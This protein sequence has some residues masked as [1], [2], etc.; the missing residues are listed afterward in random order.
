MNLFDMRVLRSTAGLFAAIVT[1]VISTSLTIPLKY[2]SGSA[3]EQS[4]ASEPVA[5]CAS[6]PKSPLA[7][8]TQSTSSGARTLRAVL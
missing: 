6:R 4:H 7:P 3:S 2:G 1:V 8:L 5:M